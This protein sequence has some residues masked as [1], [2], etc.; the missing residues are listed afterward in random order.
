[1][2][3]GAQNHLATASVHLTHI[4]V[5]NGSISGD[6][7]ATKFLG[8]IQTKH[9]VILVNRTAHTAEGVVAVGQDIRDGELLQ[10]RGTRRL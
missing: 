8:I 10:T 4:L 5:Q 2:G 9:M 7:D 1:M 6:K 3:V